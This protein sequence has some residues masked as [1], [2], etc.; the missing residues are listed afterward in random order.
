MSLILE[1]LKKSER[2][3]RLGET[4]SIGSPVIVVR[5]RRSLL[6]LLVGLIVL[7]LAVGW[8]LRREPAADAPALVQA[9]TPATAPANAP[10]PVAAPAATT[11]PAADPG[12]DMSAR[13]KASTQ[14]P[15]AERVTSQ[16][17][18]RQPVS[19]VPADANAG[20][21]ASVREKLES[22]ELVVANP[23]LLK[24]GQPATI[25]AGAPAAAAAPPSEPVAANEVP[26]EKYYPPGT[27]PQAVAVPAPTPAPASTAS[28][29]PADGRAVALLWEL[30][31]AVRREIPELKVSM[32]V[33][34]A[35]PASR[36]VIVNGERRAEGDEFEGLKLVEIRTD[37]IVFE[38]QGQRF[39]YPRGGR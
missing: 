19:K 11:A 16:A 10:P 17:A 28:A 34:A 20:L 30:P 24:P 9:P 2:Q 39:L 14:A 23:A 25:D 26:E 13:M 21:P 29:A 15:A 8:W 33:F 22:G 36:F 5:R 18:T 3:R 32:H 1:A 37:G 31:F 7:A 38:R 35:E 12:F 6:P 4:P 27:L